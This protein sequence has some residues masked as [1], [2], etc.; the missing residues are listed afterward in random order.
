[1]D[2]LEDLGNGVNHVA[3]VGAGWAGLAGAVTLADRGVRVTV[4]EASRSLGGRARKVDVEGLALDNGQHIL[5]GAY[6]ETLALMRKVGADPAR[7]LLRV[8]LT[9]RFADGFHLRA[10]RLP[11]PFNLLA[12]LLVARGL[13]FSESLAAMRFMSRLQRG[14][15]RVDPDRIVAALLHECGQAG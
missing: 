11:Y 5:I 9:L 6:R 13:S 3:I 8:P 15:F 14:A 4:Y 10:P 12:G 7:L 1:M 2:R